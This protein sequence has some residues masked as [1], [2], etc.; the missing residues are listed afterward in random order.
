MNIRNLTSLQQFVE[1]IPLR[2]AT[3]ERRGVA[4]FLNQY[5]LYPEPIFYSLKLEIYEEDHFGTLSL[6]RYYIDVCF[7]SRNG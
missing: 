1:K 6:I 2:A 3:M 7:G 4:R 5:S